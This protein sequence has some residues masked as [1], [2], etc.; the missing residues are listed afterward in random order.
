MRQK[1]IKS[2]Y[3][4]RKWEV[5]RGMIWFWLLQA[6]SFIFFL[7]LCL[8]PEIFNWA[9]VLFAILAGLDF[10]FVLIS[11]RVLKQRFKEIE[12]GES[13]VARQY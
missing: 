9:K 10:I 3:R 4:Q 8:V 1:N 7:W 13:D 6:A 12:G 11:I 2:I 5:V